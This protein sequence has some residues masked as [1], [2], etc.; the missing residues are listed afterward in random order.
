MRLANVA[1]S[2]ARARFLA[3]ANDA[4]L[5][6]TLG[7]AD[8]LRRV[9]DNVA[10]RATVAPLTWGH[11]ASLG[12]AVEDIPGVSLYAGGPAALPTLEKDL[13][14][15]KESVAVYWPMALA[16]HHFAPTLLKTCNPDRVRMHVTTRQG[17]RDFQIG[18]H[19]TRIWEVSA[20]QTL[21]AIAIDQKRLWLYVQPESPDGYVV[22]LDLAQTTKLLAS[23]W[24]MIPE[25][26]ARYGTIE[27]RINEG[28][29]PIG[30]T[31]PRCGGMLWI[32]SGRIGHYLACTTNGCGY[33]KAMTLGDANQLLRFMGVRCGDCGAQVAARK[34][35]KGLFVGCMRHPDCRWTKPLEALV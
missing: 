34:G 15:A 12:L 33:T 9:L 30:T 7:H 29:S 22:R 6:R 26:E 20:R 24:Q 5:K 2:R 13:Q 32:Q 18:L 16:R 14:A 8:S 19:N 27:E 31:C 23:L 11:M 10:T 25:D 17:H 4:Y 21:G 28:K 35:F 3:V 1:V